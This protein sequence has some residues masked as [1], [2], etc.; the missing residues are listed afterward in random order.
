M[1]SAHAPTEEKDDTEKE[2]FYDLLS[3][4]C[5]QI[6]KCD[7]LIILGDFNAQIGRENYIAQVAGKYTI[8]DET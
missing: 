2:E 6:P 1:L 8:H 3:K 7:M 5:D 4:T